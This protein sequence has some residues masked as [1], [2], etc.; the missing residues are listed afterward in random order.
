MKIRNKR[1]EKGKKVWKAQINNAYRIVT[2]K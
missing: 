2:L 1:R